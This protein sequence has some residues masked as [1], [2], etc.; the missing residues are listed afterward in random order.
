MYLYVKTFFNMSVFAKAVFISG[1]SGSW[2]AAQQNIP[3]QAQS[4][5]FTKATN[6]IMMKS[7]GGMI[8]KKS[9]VRDI[10]HSAGIKRLSQS[11]IE[12]LDEAVERVVRAM[13]G[14][15]AVVYEGR[16]V[17]SRELARLST[18]KE[19]DYVVVVSIIESEEKSLEEIVEEEPLDEGEE[20]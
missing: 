10:F 19:K 13:A 2:R 17:G 15:A 5:I 6:S 3:M 1:M 8:L 14:D 11:A 7:Q 16:L 9:V 4:V 12:S 18:I 20:E